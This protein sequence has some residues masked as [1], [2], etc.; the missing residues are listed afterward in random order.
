[1]VAK[2]R[3]TPKKVAPARIV[4]KPRAADRSSSG[5]ARSVNQRPKAG[6]SKEAAAARKQRFIEAY[7]ANGGNASDAAKAAGYS[8]HSAAQ[9]ASRLLTDAKVSQQIADRSAKLAKKYELTTD[10]VVRSIVQEMTFDPANLYDAAGRL[11]PITELDEDT[12]MALVGL[13]IIEETA[14]GAVGTELEPQPHGGGLKRQTGQR[15]LVSRT[16]KVKWA[17]K[18][19]AREQAMKHLGMFKADNAQRTAVEGVPREV[20]LAIAE[21]LKTLAHGA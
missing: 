6:T 14:Q 1:M 12:R 9:Q 8:A 2:K 18:Q 16:A 15:V 20:L 5:K 21:R 11:K 4:G 13:E 7:I 3:A 17:P 19:G 10:L